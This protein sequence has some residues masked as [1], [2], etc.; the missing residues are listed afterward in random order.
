MAHG[1]KRHALESMPASPAGSVPGSVAP[2]RAF[3]GLRLRVDSGP[4]STCEEHA[5]DFPLVLSYLQLYAVYVAGHRP[6]RTPL[7]AFHVP[8][9]FATLQLHHMVATRGDP[10]LDFALNLKRRN[11]P[12]EKEFLQYAR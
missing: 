3:A 4:D 10:A 12:L 8:S 2:R 11:Q 7:T 9:N 6:T 5:P 1:V